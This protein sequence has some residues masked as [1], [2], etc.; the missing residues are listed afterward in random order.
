MAGTEK[1]RL[2]GRTALVTG[3]GRGLGRAF[4]LALSRAGASVA[5]ADI[6]LGNARAVHSEISN[7]GGRSMAVGVDVS[8]PGECAEM[9]RE[10][11]GRW[12]KLD[13]AV[14][15]AGVSL[16]EGA[17]EV[18]PESWEKIIGVN[19]RGVFFCAQAEARAMIPAG[20]GKIINTASICG[21]R[22]WP[23]YQPVYSISKAGVLH[24]TRCLAV[25]W[26]ASGIRVNSISPGVTEIP[27]LFPEV[28][29]DF[30]ARAPAGRTGRVQDLLGA[31]LYLASPASDF[32]VGQDLVVDGGY[33]IG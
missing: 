22:V 20:Y 25:E 11:V 7:L 30:L 24:L 3:A 28:R 32:M 26:A 1:D 6:D 8:R 4:A 27:D 17:L 31:L 2:D 12:G 10:V 23:R 29:G 19:L 14:N 5:V 15:N 16:L 13:I 18:T 21:H 33:V 9:V